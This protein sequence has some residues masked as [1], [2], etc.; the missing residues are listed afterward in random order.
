[1]DL[2]RVGFVYDMHQGYLRDWQEYVL[3]LLCSVG[4]VGE[5]EETELQVEELDNWTTPEDAG[6][7]LDAATEE[8]E[9]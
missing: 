2:F 1:M 3:I 8:T 7:R 5:D 6:L 9:A 4:S